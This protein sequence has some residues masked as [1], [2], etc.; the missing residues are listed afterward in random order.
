MCCGDALNVFASS[1]L[2]N[3]LDPKQIAVYLQVDRGR[4]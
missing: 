1:F 4:I 3:L 2:F